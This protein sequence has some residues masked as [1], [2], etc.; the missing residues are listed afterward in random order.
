MFNYSLLKIVDF[1]R[2]CKK[3]H[4]TARQAT[5]ENIMHSI[6]DAICMLD[7]AKIWTHIHNI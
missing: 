3:N 1:K 7:K 4:S 5:D 2:Q 6:K